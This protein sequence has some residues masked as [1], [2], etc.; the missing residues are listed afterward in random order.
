M[1]VRALAAVAAGLAVVMMVL[2][3]VAR[4]LVEA[5]KAL[6]GRRWCWRRWRGGWGWR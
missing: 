6:V 5:A 3:E 1:A 4:A 2:A